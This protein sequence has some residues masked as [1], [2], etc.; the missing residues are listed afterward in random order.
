MASFFS[1]KI[2]LVFLPVSTRC[3]ARVY[4]AP[5]PA[6][7][8]PEAEYNIKHGFFF[9]T[10][11]SRISTLIFLFSLALFFKPFL[12]GVFL[13]LYHLSFLLHWPLSCLLCYI[14]FSLSFYTILLFSFFFTYTIQLEKNSALLII[15]LPID[16]LLHP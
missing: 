12:S 15:D 2:L 7:Q 16:L 6:A 9:I 5:D 14:P 1:I 13:F 8:L 11:A 10:I 3:Y 4:L